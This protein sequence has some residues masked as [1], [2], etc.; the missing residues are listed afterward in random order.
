MRSRRLL[1]GGVGV[2][3]A[4]GAIGGAWILA[5]LGN[6]VQPEPLNEFDHR[7]HVDS[8]PPMRPETKIPTS[9][10]LVPECACPTIRRSSVQRRSG[11]NATIPGDRAASR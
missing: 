9:A 7:F 2:V 3:G 4:V 1:S 8:L 11:R 6:M 5:A 10:N